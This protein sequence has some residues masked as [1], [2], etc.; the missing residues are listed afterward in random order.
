MLHVSK[1]G[2][3]LIKKNDPLSSHLNVGLN[4]AKSDRLW[5]HDHIP[6]C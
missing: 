2:V 6:L 3:N 1:R 5:D 4:V